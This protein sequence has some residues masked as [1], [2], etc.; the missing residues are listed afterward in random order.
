MGDAG[1]WFPRAGSPLAAEFGARTIE[2]KL[3]TDHIE[4]GAARKV[5]EKAGVPS[6]SARPKHVLQCAFDG[7]RISIVSGGGAAED[8]PFLDDSRAIQ[9]GGG[10]GSTIGH[11]AFR[12]SKAEALDLLGQVAEICAGRTGLARGGYGGLPKA[13]RLWSLGVIP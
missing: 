10:S 5:Y 12:R 6:G 11:N 2:M 13:R 7:R 1:A 9:T 8:A 4:R 3:P